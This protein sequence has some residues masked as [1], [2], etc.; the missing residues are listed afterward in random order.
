LPGSVRDIARRL[1]HADFF[2]LSS[3]YEGFPNAL[4]EAMQMGLACASFDC[5]S[6]PRELVV[7]GRN[8]LL[9]ASDDVDGLS[10]ALRRLADDKDLRSR[11]GK[12]AAKIGEGFSRSKVY[13][14]W[15]SLVDFVADG[16]RGAN[17]PDPMREC[18]NNEPELT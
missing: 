8:G 6:G 10:R 9:V 11:L 5:P 2:V 18:K 16:G 12:E 3:R 4:L 1:V 13:G 14:K 7:D 15:L 17:S